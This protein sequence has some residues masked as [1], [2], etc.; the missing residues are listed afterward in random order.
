L[1][2]SDRREA[3]PESPTSCDF[4]KSGQRRSA[5]VGHLPR[6]AT[7]IHIGQDSKVA[8]SLLKAFELTTFKLANLGHLRRF[9]CAS[10]RRAVSVSRVSCDQLRFRLGLEVAAGL[11]HSLLNAGEM[12]SMIYQTPKSADCGACAISETA[13][14]IRI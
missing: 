5:A 2:I 4:S 12:L 11:L 9:A 6:S 3:L 8:E 10:F 7:V 13:S 1:D 14:Y